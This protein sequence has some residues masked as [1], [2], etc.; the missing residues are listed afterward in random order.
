MEAQQT[1]LSSIQ[2]AALR[3]NPI[4]EG[5]RSE[6]ERGE[7]WGLRKKADSRLEERMP[8]L[9]SLEKGRRGSQTQGEG[10]ERIENGKRKI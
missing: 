2:K 6:K 1:I 9:K 8:N 4:R 10:V 5:P 3:Q 7:K